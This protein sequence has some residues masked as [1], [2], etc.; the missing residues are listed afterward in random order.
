MNRYRMPIGGEWVDAAGGETFDRDHPFLGAA[1]TLAPRAAPADVDRAVEA[2]RNAFRAP[3]RRRISATARGSVMPASD[4]AHHCEN[5]ESGRPFAATFPV[6]GALE[7]YDNLR[8]VAPSPEH[9][10]PGRDPLVM[11]LYPPPRCDLKGVAVRLD[12]ASKPRS[13]ISRAARA[14]LHHGAGLGGR[15]WTPSTGPT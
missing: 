2:A 12:V 6:G 11:R 1:S 10:A 15:I 14:A 9:R 8:A 5:M 13:A 3:T 7:G 4:V